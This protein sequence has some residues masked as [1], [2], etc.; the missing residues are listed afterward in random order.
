MHKLLQDTALKERN[1]REGTRLGSV[2]RPIYSPCR[3]LFCIKQSVLA[4]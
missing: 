4:P 1:E 3:F 2:S